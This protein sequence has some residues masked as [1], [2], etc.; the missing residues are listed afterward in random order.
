M[1]LLSDINLDEVIFSPNGKDLT[2]KFVNMTDG[3]LINIIKCKSIFIFTYNNTF[4]DD[5]GFACYVGEVTCERISHSNLKKWL[6]EK[7]FSFYDV[8]KSIYVPTTRDLFNL[9]IEGGQIVID[10]ACEAIEKD[11]VMVNSN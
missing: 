2:F 8:D 1:Q 6:T 3:A 11:G 4:E 5:D 7:R 10:L 9:H